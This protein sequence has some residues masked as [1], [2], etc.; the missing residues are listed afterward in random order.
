MSDAWSREDGE[1]TAAETG[2]ALTPEHW[3]VI[4]FARTDF[5]E[6][7]QTPGLRRIV[8]SIGVPMKSLYEMF[9]KGPGKLI[10]KIG[11]LPPPKSCL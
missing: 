7:K 3:K 5:R 9:P 10:A 6:T 2:I 4:E 11:G 1:R 8:S